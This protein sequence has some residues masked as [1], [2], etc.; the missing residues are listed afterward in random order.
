MPGQGNVGIGT[1]TPSAKLHVEGNAKVTGNAEVNGNLGIG[2][3]TPSEKLHVGGNAIVSGK[4]AIRT[5]T[6]TTIDL[7]IG[8]NDTG[9]KQEA[10]GKLAIYTNGA[11]RVLIDNNGNVGIGTGTANPSAKL[12]VKGSVKLGE[13]STPWKRFIF[14]FVNNN[15]SSTGTGF[16]VTT[17]E[18]FR[19]FSGYYIRL[20]EPIAS[21]EKCI[22]LVLPFPDQGILNMRYGWAENEIYVKFKKE[23][24][25]AKCSFNFI[26]IEAI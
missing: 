2:I 14:G 6:P 19:P 17:D 23:R 25:F 5:T 7:A 24:E 18:G 20:T 12:H 1:T 4:L 26:L 11:G 13:F 21:K 3:T 9:L 16:I 10:D 15:G 8:D 22:F